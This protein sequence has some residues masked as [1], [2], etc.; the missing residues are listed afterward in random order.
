[1]TNKVHVSQIDDRNLFFQD[2]STILAASSSIIGEVFQ[3]S[4]FTHIAGW[5]YSDVD[6]ATNGLI[7][8]QALDAADFPSGSAATSNVTVTTLTITGA[9]IINNAFAVQIVAPYARVI[10]TNGG[11][12]QATFRASFEA[13]I[14]RGL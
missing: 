6:S 5:A 13:R 7:I 3:V 10:Y 9:D 14:L 4:G 1:M 8:E 11:S 12:P 2:G